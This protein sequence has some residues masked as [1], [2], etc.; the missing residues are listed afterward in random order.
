[1]EVFRQY[2]EKNIL[3]IVQEVGEYLHAKLQAIVDK[4][5]VAK[6]TRGV[7]LMQGLELTIPA[8]DIILKALDKGLIV[9][10]AGA[11]IIR[12]V[13]PL[14]ITKENVDEMAA[15]LEDILAGI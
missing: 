7:G 8:G 13:P 11:N 10:S 9:I 3:G 15:I 4:Y 12:F 2:E 14:V 6:E 5:D 1:N